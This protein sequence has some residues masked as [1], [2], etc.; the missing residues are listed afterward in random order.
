MEEDPECITGD[1]YAKKHVVEKSKLFE[2][3]NE[4]PKAVIHHLHL[5]AACPLRYLIKLT[6]REC[7]YYN[8]KLN[9]FKVTKNEFNE[10]GF[11]KCN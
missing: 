9:L 6:Y 2:A 4:M 8:Q 7:V 10:E 1:F 5:T 3:L 11:I